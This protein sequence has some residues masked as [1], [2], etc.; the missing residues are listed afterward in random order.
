MTYIKTLFAAASILAL[1]GC[2]L[3]QPYQRP[4]AGAPVAYPNGPAYAPDEPSGKLAASDTGWAEFLGDAS[5]R[6]LVPRRDAGVAL[7]VQLHQAG[8]ALA[9][10]WRGI[11]TARLSSASTTS[12]TPSASEQAWRRLRRISR[13]SLA[14]WRICPTI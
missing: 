3:Q 11:S 4:P 13:L 2:S 14:W 6:R 5:L 10:P 7:L 1:A 8:A 12:G 9:E